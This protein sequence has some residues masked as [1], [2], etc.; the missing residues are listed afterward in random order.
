MW[1]NYSCGHDCQS[2]VINC[3]LSDHIPCYYMYEI[4]EKIEDPIR[5]SRPLHLDS[6]INELVCAVSRI[7]VR[8]ICSLQNPS[9]FMPRVL[10]TMYK[11]Y[12][13]SFPISYKKRSKP[14]WLS[15]YL[16]YVIKKR[17]R[18]YKLIIYVDINYS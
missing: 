12:Y 8:E 3:D 16:L 7:P 15:E 18:L 17:H 13:E 6:C 9:E 14:P 2:D 1:C 11:A 10:K 4:S 5:K